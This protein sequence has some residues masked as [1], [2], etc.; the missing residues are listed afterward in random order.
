MRQSLCLSTFKSAL[1][2]LLGRRF[3]TVPWLALLVSAV[4]EQCSFST[5]VASLGDSSEGS[6]LTEGARVSAAGLCCGA[7]RLIASSCRRRSA[8]RL[9]TPPAPGS[10]VSA[11]QPSAM[12]FMALRSR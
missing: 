9:K 11:Q 8:R 10:R 5:L 7:S 4:G 6:Q 3:C 2:H 1:Q 12:R